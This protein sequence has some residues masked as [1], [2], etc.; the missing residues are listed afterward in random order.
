MQIYIQDLDSQKL[1]FQQISDDDLGK[2]ILT[3]SID[4][5]M[6]TTTPLIVMH[7][8]PL[9]FPLN[10][11]VTGLIISMRPTIYRLISKKH[12]KIIAV[13]DEENNSFLYLNPNKTFA[14]VSL[15]L[16]ASINVNAFSAL[17]ELTKSNNSQL[18]C[19]TFQTL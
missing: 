6:K 10:A 2:E 4:N 8:M 18:D 15:P 14:G 12:K 7:L 5:F 1:V 11:V 17:D 3:A 16:I 19:K 13:Y 9:H